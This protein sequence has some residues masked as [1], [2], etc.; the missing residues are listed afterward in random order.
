[1]NRVFKRLITVGAVCFPIAMTGCHPAPQPQP[2]QQLEHI[3]LADASQGHQTEP[4][5]SSPVLYVAPGEEEAFYVRVGRDAKLTFE[6]ASPSGKSVSPLEISLHPDNETARVLI[7]CA[8]ACAEQTLDLALDPQSTG[9]IQLVFSVTGPSEDPDDGWQVLAPR[10]EYQSMDRSPPILVESNTDIE[11]RPNLIIYLSDALR[12]DGLGVYGSK[13]GLS[14]LIDAFAER[15]T[16]LERATAQ[17]PWTRS[18]VASIFT[19]LDPDRHGITDRNDALAP[20]A[21]TLAELLSQS[22]YYTAA[23]ITNGNVGPQFGMDQGFDVFLRSRNKDLSSVQTTD[24]ALELLSVPEFREPFFL[25]IHNL[26]PHHPYEIAEPAFEHLV[27]DPSKPELGSETVLKSVRQRKRQLDDEERGTVKQLYDS[28]VAYMD[29]EF[30][31]FLATVEELGYYDNSVIVFI[32][33]HG[34]EFW[35]HER[36]G[37]G[38]SVYEELTAIPLIIKT[39]AQVDGE[40]VEDPVRQ[41]DVFATLLDYANAPI[42]PSI[43]GRSLLAAATGP[44]PRYALLG[45]DGRHAVSIID[46]EWKLV[47]SGKNKKQELLFNLAS[48]PGEHQNLVHQRPVMA[49]YLQSQLTAREADSGPSLESI[50]G[51]LDDEL[52]D[53]LR[54]LGYLE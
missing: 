11:E 29:R 47:L 51:E 45:L 24:R 38:I 13:Q 8:S 9:V 16:V 52:K 37:H 12:R 4:T 33:D 35:D 1:M 54:A 26:D 31:R 50:A 25:Y 18:A 14:P 17:A 5:Q 30:G 10:I 42:P 2:E 53:Q 23:A 6:G 15:A 3:N 41:T 40:R 44:T 7:R 20:E 46:G 49:G 32:S 36:W 22:G 28:E 34:E 21:L 39:P 27:D 43:D 48:D 19:G